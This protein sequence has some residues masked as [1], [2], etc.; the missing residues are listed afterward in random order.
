MISMSDCGSQDLLVMGGI[1]DKR[2]VMQEIHGDNIF[3][4]NKKIS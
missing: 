3:A 1:Q 2:M 4:I